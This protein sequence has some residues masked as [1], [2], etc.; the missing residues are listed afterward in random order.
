MLEIKNLSKKYGNSPVKAVDNLSLKLKKGEVCNVVCEINYTPVKM[1]KLDNG[2][3]VIAD[4]NI[5][6]I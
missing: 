6:K 3:Y 2:Y 5:Q 1:Y 4:Q